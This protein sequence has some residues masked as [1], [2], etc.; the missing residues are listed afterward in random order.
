MIKLDA[1]FI[2]PDLKHTRLKRDLEPATRQHQR[3]L[4]HKPSLATKKHKK[5]QLSKAI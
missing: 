5:S 4:R 2:E 1:R 3:S